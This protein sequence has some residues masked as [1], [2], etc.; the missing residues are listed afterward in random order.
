MC[1]SQKGITSSRKTYDTQS[2]ALRR[3]F[4][5]DISNNM[6]FST[7]YV[8]TALTK[9][10]ASF[11]SPNVTLSTI[12][13]PNLPATISTLSGELFSTAQFISLVYTSTIISYLPSTVAGL[14]TAGYVSTSFYDDKTVS[15]V[16]GLGT[17]GYVSTSFY[18]A[19]TLSTVQGLGTVGY[20]STSFYDAKLVSTVEGLG[21]AGYLSSAVVQTPIVSTVIGLGTVGYISSS[22]LL[23]SLTGLGSLG[24]VSSS[25]LTSSINGLVTLGFISSSQ[26]TSS[27]TSSLNGLG[28]LGYISSSQLFSSITSLGS[29]GYVSTSQLTSTVAGLA[30]S[31]YVSTT[32]LTSSIVGL[33][34]I[35]YLSTSQIFRSTYSNNLSGNWSN[36]GYLYSSI[37]A[38]TISLSSIRFELGAALRQQIIPSTTKLDIELKPNIQ[39]VYYDAISRDYQFNSFL[40]RGVNFSTPNIIGQES[41]TYYILNANAIN[42]AFFFQEKTRFLI[43]NPLVLSTLRNDTQFSTLSLHHTFGAR[44][45]TTNQFFATPASSICA[46]VVLDNTV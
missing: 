18:D 30:S 17:V 19:K 45:P 25:Q 41:I 10:T 31:R 33:G 23:S 29:L 7:G 21:T 38:T 12:G 15:T 43:N 39:F 4:A 20:V 35:G 13:F 22:Q 46:S 40:V 5:Y 2:I 6:P 34:S 1:D 16:Q 36:V 42:L 3:I 44:V 9:G 28:T 32:Q 14:G 11:V 8:L 27:L 37:S 24:Y 26:L